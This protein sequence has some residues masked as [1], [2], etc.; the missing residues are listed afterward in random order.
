M[1]EARMMKARARY[2]RAVVDEKPERVVTPLFR[3]FINH[4]RL[5]CDI[6]AEMVEV[7]GGR[8]EWPK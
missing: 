4:A 8:R 5:F 7:A 6:H 2:F 3:K 1:A